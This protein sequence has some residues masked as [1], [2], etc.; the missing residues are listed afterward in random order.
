MA[1]TSI[2]P[3]LPRVSAT[4]EDNFEPIADGWVA[5][6]AVSRL[7]KR[8]KDLQTTLSKGRG[9]IA[10]NVDWDLTNPGYTYVAVFELAGRNLRSAG[11]S[12]SGADGAAA[13][14][15]QLAGG[16]SSYS[17]ITVDLKPDRYHA[18]QIA[19]DPRSQHGSTPPAQLSSL[20]HPEKRPAFVKDASADDQRVNKD[21]RGENVTDSRPCLLMME[22]D[23]R[24]SRPPSLIVV[25]IPTKNG[26]RHVPMLEREF[27][28]MRIIF[29]ILQELSHQIPRHSILKMIAT[30]YVRSSLRS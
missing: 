15:F 27:T 8:D 13:R 20:C 7:E 5:T 23:Q 26:L 25:Y 17:F 18:I 28:S 22:Q 11:I 1:G 21:T 30:S 19:A 9:H 12:V 16:P 24:M 10:R 4:F 14:S 2:K 29:W 3:I 6:G